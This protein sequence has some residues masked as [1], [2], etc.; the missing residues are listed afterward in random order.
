M[1]KELEKQ[2]IEGLAGTD[3]VKASRNGGFLQE[4]TP[5]GE[6]LSEIFVPPGTHRAVMFMRD[7]GNGSLLIPGD[8]V[9]CYTPPVKTKA[10]EF[11]AM[12]YETA[13]AQNFKVDDVDRIE[14]ANRF[15]E[16]RLDA[17]QRHQALL[18][19]ALV[20]SRGGDPDALA[21]A[22]AAARAESEKAEAEKAEAE[23]AKLEAEKAK[24]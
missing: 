22:E 14:R 21:D 13:A 9:A 12:A 6:L 8:D 1:T 3:V 4:V 15:L 7:I 23:K 5:D 10:T 24:A 18:D 11:G 2:K 19:R 17:I 16:R 20:R